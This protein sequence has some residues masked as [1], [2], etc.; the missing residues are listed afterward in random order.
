MYSLV[1]LFPN[2]EPVLCCMSGSNCCFLNL[3]VLPCF[4]FLFCF[5]FFVC[6]E[7]SL[8][9]VGF[10]SCGVVSVVVCG[11]SCPAACGILVSRPVME[12]TF[13]ALQG[14]FLTTGAVLSRL[15]VSD[16]LRPHGL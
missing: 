14:G 6:V 9:H 8:W 5:L 16:S 2:F 3:P 10:S 13:P 12:P 1:I 7:S 4:Q 15:V 11:P